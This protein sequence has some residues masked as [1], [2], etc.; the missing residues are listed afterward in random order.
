[1]LDR[2]CLGAAIVPA[3]SPIFARVFLSLSFRCEYIYIYIDGAAKLKRTK[4]W[5]SVLGNNKSGKI[6]RKKEKI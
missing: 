4:L 3:R 6:V 2:R 1:M 5:L